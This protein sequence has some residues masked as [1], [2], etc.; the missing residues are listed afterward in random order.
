MSAHFLHQQ[1]TIR[2]TYFGIIYQ[3]TINVLHKPPTQ[4]FFLAKKKV[5]IKYPIM[6][7]E[8]LYPIT[9][10]NNETRTKDIPHMT[11]SNGIRP[12]HLFIDE[13]LGG[14]QLSLLSSSQ[15]LTKMRE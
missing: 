4:A 2:R 10:T 7:G 9:N 13:C 5:L 14:E 6:P 12:T 15:T 11:T 3:W 1:D 8:P